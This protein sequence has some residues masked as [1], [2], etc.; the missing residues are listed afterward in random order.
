MLVCK[1]ALKY[2]GSLIFSFGSSKPKA[3]N[4]WIPVNHLHMPLWSLQIFITHASPQ[5]ILNSRFMQP[6]V[7][8]RHRRSTLWTKVQDHETLFRFTGG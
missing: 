1:F 2:C 7:S 3:P 6:D 8:N 4:D 5:C